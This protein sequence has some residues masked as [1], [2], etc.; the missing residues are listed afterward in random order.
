MTLTED[1]KTKFNSRVNTRID[2]YNDFLMK[3]PET[4]GKGFEAFLM[5]ELTMLH[6]KINYLEKLL[7]S[8]S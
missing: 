7:K 3:Y 4:D 1:Q 6:D 2:R 8:Q 5:H